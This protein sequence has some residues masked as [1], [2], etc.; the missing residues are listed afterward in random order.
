MNCDE[1]RAPLQ[2]RME[3]SSHQSQRL[4]QGRGSE[5][6]DEQ[7]NRKRERLREEEP[8]GLRYVQ[9]RAVR[10]GGKAGPEFPIVR[11]AIGHDVWNHLKEFSVRIIAKLADSKFVWAGRTVHYLLCRHL[12][13]YKREIWSLVVDQPIRFILHKF[14]EITVLNTDPLL[15]EIFEPDQ[16]KMFWEELNVLH[17]VGPKLDG[18]KPALEVCR[19]WS[20]EK[21]KWLRLLVLQAMGLNVLHHNSRIPFESA[22]R[23][24][25]DEVMRSYPWGQTAYEVLVD[26]IKLLYPQGRSYTIN[27]LKDVLQVWAYE[28]LTC[29]EDRFGRVVDEQEILLFRWGGKR[30]HASFATIGKVIIDLFIRKMV[31]KESAQDM[32][33]QWPGEADDPQFVNL[34][35]DIHADKKHKEVADVEKKNEN[36][37]GKGATKDEGRTIMA[38]PDNISR[39]F[40]NYDGRFE[41]F[42]SR[43]WAY[44]SNIRELSRNISNINMSIGDRVQAAVDERLKVLG[45]KEIYI[46]TNPHPTSLPSPPNLPQK[47]VNSLPAME[48]KTHVSKGPGTKKSLGEQVSKA[49]AKGLGAKMN[50]EDEVAKTTEVKKNLVSEVLIQSSMQNSSPFWSKHISFIDSWYPGLWVHDYKM[51]NLNPKQFKFKG[52]GYEELTNNRI[53]PDVPKNL[54]WLEDVDHLYGVIN[55]GGDHFVKI[56]DAFRP[57]TQMIP[58][59]MNEIIH[60]N[61]RK[62]SYKQ[63]AFRRRKDKYIP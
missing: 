49:N 42:D 38:T 36:A 19:N 52:T 3:P 62:P 39:Q 20:F 16:Y 17:G 7:A 47:S 2:L 60:V 28:S 21:G 18:L 43:F 5:R 46:G 57:V 40:D 45:A 31:M 61:I 25:D 4:K 35:S 29:F 22:K 13:V 44:D 63:F 59:M 53:L 48:Y 11:E 12:Q 10:A 26:S 50:L 41:M 14:G 37:E 1:D 56:L 32:F 34:I 9:S 33:P 55:V 24:F 58:A 30:T 54:K 8:S 23:V 6:V 15:T 51:F 27:G